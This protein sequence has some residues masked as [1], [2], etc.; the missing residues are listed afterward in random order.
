MGVPLEAIGCRPRV[1]WLHLSASAS[2]LVGVTDAPRHRG[3]LVE[4]ACLAY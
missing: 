4:V 1:G 3:F 2:H